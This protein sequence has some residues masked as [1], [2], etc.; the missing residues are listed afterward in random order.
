MTTAAH[1]WA[2]GYDNMERADQVRDEIARLSHRALHQQDQNDKHRRQNGAQPEDVEVGHRPRLPLA[3]VLQLLPGLLKGASRVQQGAFG[4]A[5]V[6]AGY[7]SLGLGTGS[8]PD[9]RTR[10]NGHKWSRP[11][12]RQH[13]HQTGRR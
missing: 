10:P 13:T 8:A 5:G 6:P 11:G 7:Q 9:G 1:L 2:I 4:Y 3:L 12:M